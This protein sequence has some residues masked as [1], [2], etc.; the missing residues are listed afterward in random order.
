MIMN[1]PIIIRFHI[2]K[3]PSHTP[4]ALSN[5]TPMILALKGWSGLSLGNSSGLRNGSERCLRGASP[6]SWENHWKKP[7]FPVCSM[8]GIFTYKTGCFLG[9]MLVNIPY[10]E[11]MGLGGNVECLNFKNL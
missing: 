4:P 10:M 6:S 7:W 3:S 11:H 5:G 8:Y 9:Q 1:H 2:K